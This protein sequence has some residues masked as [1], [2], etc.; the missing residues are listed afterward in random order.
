MPVPHSDICFHRCVDFFQT[1]KRNQFQKVNYTLG[2][3]YIQVL[4]PF[5]TLFW[6]QPWTQHFRPSN[7]VSV[8]W[9]T[10]YLLAICSYL[11]NPR[12]LMN[13]PRFLASHISVIFA[14]LWGTYSERRRQNSH[15][16]FILSTAVKIENAK[17]M[18]VS[19]ALKNESPEHELS[20]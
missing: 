15:S 4:L 8:R 16:H 3:I 7:A 17:L 2:Y 18:Y 12:D 14:V 20:L 1:I 5:F 13:L 19:D 6:V 9:G 10:S 11:P